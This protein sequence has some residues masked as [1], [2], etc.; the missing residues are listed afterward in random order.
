MCLVDRKI[1]KADADIRTFVEHIGLAIPDLLCGLDGQKQSSVLPADRSIHAHLSERTVNFFY[2]HIAFDRIK[3]SREV[4]QCGSVIALFKSIGGDAR[5]IPIP[6]ITEI[7]FNCESVWIIPRK[8]KSKYMV[9]TIESAAS[10]T[11]PLDQRFL[12]PQV[13]VQGG[14]L[15]VSPRY[16]IRTYLGAGGESSRFLTSKRLRGSVGDSATAR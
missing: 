3:R 4:S 7:V 15:P 16:V 1:H 2:S 11:S 9:D 12:R 10:V 8:C 13:F 6:Q 14:I 5:K